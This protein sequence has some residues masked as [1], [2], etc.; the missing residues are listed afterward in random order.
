MV[1]PDERKVA[2]VLGQYGPRAPL[3]LCR[4]GPGSVLVTH[5]RVAWMLHLW[6]RSIAVR[7]IPPDRK[8]TEAVFSGRR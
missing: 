1:V 8:G 2:V 6:F 5:T 4:G 3:L 7:W